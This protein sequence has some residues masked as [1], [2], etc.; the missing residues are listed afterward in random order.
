MKNS[1][2][3]LILGGSGLVGYSLV[4]NLKNSAKCNKI[5]YPNR[6]ELDLFDF[7]KTKKYIE[8]CKPDILINAA[9][10]VGG[11][12]ANN[13]LR[14]EFILDN[15]KINI[16]VLESCINLEQIVI[17]NLGSSC[18]Y[19]KNVPNPI[20]EEYFMSGKLEETNS[21]YAMAK[22]AAIEIGDSISK[23]YG[24]KI[25]NLMPTNLF[26][27][28]DFFSENRSHVIPSMIHK[29][30]LAKLENHNEY[31]VWGSGKPLRE[32]LYVDDFS[33]I[34]EFLIDKEVDEKI[35]NIG[36]GFE[37]SIRHLAENIKEVI[38]FKGKLVF[39]LEKPDGINKKLLDSSKLKSLG[40]NKYSDFNDSLVK[41]YKW[42]LK[43]INSNRIEKQL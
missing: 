25:I 42:Y 24:K 31:S 10:K 1:Y 38:E 7:N 5:F 39:D 34:V 29:M 12:L 18:I 32:F 4:N 19:P 37:I 11:V 28:N 8:D 30:H 27:P 36:S 43:N 16:N 21:P 15:L 22:I 17:F 41:T 40:W 6:N 9:A 33:K 26:G 2:K 14:T 20:K 23:Q 13:T 35:L 3:I